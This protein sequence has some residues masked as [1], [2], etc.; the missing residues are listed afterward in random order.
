MSLTYYSCLTALLKHIKSKPTLEPGAPGS[1][2]W[3]LKPWLEREGAANQSQQ[4]AYHQVLPS[5]LLLVTYRESPEPWVSW[6]SSFTLFALKGNT[7]SE[8]M[9]INKY[10]QNLPVGVQTLCALWVISINLQ[11]LL[12]H[13]VCHLFPFC[14]AAPVIKENNYLGSTSKTQ[15]PTYGFILLPKIITAPSRNC[16][17]M[18]LYVLMIFL[19]IKPGSPGGPWIPLRP[20]LPWCKQRQKRVTNKKEMINS[21]YYGTGR[22]PTR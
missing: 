13:L 15:R 8:Q 4:F 21:H 10:R 3:P 6:G 11:V 9:W 7:L 20:S 12:V 18:M 5:D 14:Q 16:I 22:W 17:F 2:L 19:T 1:P